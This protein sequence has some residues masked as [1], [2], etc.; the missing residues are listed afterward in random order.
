MELLKCRFVSAEI[1]AS[2]EVRAI[3]PPRA[4][5]L[6]ITWPT[7]GGVRHSIPFVGCAKDASEIPK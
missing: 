1:Q 7:G 2:N 5:E 6:F 4:L 3:P